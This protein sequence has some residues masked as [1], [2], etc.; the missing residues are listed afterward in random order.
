MISNY[1][2]S[3]KVL[4]TLHVGLKIQLLEHSRI[5]KQCLEELLGILIFHVR[6]ILGDID[7]AKGKSL[8]LQSIKISRN[9]GCIH[10]KYDPFSKSS[11]K[12]I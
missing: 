7:K 9:G 4:W 2:I 5:L 1:D 6:V 12:I 10:S 11:C 3:E 8:T